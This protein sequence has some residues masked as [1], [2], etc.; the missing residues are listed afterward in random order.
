[1]HGTEK[2]RSAS[3]VI[4]LI[5]TNQYFS[6]I[7]VPKRIKCV[8][9]CSGS[10]ACAGESISDCTETHLL[11][12]VRITLC[13]VLLIFLISSFISEKQNS[14]HFWRIISWDSV[15]LWSPLQSWDHEQT[16]NWI[17]FYFFVSTH[18]R[19]FYINLLLSH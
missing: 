18:I 19:Q 4:A 14:W 10:G 12:P 17:T 16:S 5:M 7:Q 11:V 6:R 3:D 15:T 1:M 9:F 2:A 13:S 8:Y